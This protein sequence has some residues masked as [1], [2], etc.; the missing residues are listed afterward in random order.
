MLYKKEYKILLIGHKGHPEVIGTMGQLP[1]GG[2]ELI[3][4]KKIF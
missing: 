2:V 3:E 4:K 1:V